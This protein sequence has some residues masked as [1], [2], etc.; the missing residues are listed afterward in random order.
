MMPGDTTPEYISY[1]DVLSNTA[2]MGR[3]LVE[4]CRFLDEAVGDLVLSKP[5]GGAV[6]VQLLQSVDA[7][8]Q[9]M[10]AIV[11][12]IENLAQQPAPEASI[13]RSSVTA[14][15]LLE[16]VRAQVVNVPER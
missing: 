1:A 8:S 5:G 13:L 4:T 11:Q 2:Q 6:D 10:A 3:T 14:N 7:L 15:V 12:V 16:A 9:S